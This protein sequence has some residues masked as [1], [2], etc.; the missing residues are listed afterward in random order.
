TGANDANGPH[1]VVTWLGQVAPSTFRF[2]GAPAGFAANVPLPITVAAAAP[3]ISAHWLDLDGDGDLDA[4]GNSGPEGNLVMQLDAE[5]TDLV[6]HDPIQRTPPAWATHIEVRYFQ[7]DIVG[8]GPE[9][10]ALRSKSLGSQLVDATATLTYLR[11]GS[12]STGPIATI[13]RYVR[14]EQETVTRLG[15]C[16]PYIYATADRGLDLVTAMADA[17]APNSPPPTMP[18]E[19]HANEALPVGSQPP[20]PGQVGGVVQ[21]PKLP[22]PDDDETQDG[23]G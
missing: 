19:L 1:V 8:T 10:L 14:I 11:H 12:L 16:T 6:A 15:G 23:S 4:I 3:G 9:R 22:P 21:P 2:L 13:V 5:A 17:M 20:A 7:V 18:V